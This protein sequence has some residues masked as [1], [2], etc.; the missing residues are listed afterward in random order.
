MSE[1]NGY[2]KNLSA[3]IAKELGYSQATVSRAIRH[4]GGVDSDTRRKILSCVDTPETS[5]RSECDI[6]VILPDTPRYFWEE[7]K[8]GVTSIKPPENITVKHNV[9][10]N[11]RDEDVI[12]YYLDEADR[13]GARVILLAALMTPSIFERVKALVQHC[14]VFFLSEW[15]G[16]PE[17]TFFFGADSYEDGAMMGRIFCEQ[18]SSMTPFVINVEQ[19]D[20]VIRRMDGFLDTLRRFDEKRFRNVPMCSISYNIAGDIRLFPSKIASILTE[21]MEANASYCLYIPFGN[22]YMSRVTQKIRGG[23]KVVCLGHDCM[24]GEDGTPENGIAATVRQDTFLQGETAIRAAIRYLE[25]GKFPNKKYIYI[26]SRIY[27]KK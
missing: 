21:V 10:T 22:L 25:T 2:E 14:A 24:V 4:C 15:G 18:Y 19:N 16:E 11:V 6:Y 23:A 20:N 7:L 3:K 17:N 5:Q 9:Y 26:P 27:E 1:Q 12:L 13:M 8:A